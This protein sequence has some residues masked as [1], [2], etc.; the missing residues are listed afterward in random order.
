MNRFLP[1]ILALAAGI[2]NYLLALLIHAVDILLYFDSLFTIVKTLVY[3]FFPGIRS[4]IILA[5]DKS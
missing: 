5:K 3:G 4:V 2:L 1:Y